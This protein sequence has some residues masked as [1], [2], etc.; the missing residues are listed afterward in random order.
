MLAFSQQ[1]GNKANTGFPTNCVELV[2]LTLVGVSVTL[3]ICP[4][5]LNKNLA[6]GK[7]KKTPLQLNILC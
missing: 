2:K 5:H 7:Y 4:F 6:S 1:R 3:Y